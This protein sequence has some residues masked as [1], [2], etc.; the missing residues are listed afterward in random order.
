[1]EFVKAR[2][3]IVSS[4]SES[5]LHPISMYL[6]TAALLA[7]GGCQQNGDAVELKVTA[8]L[9]SSTCGAAVELEDTEE[10]EVTLTREDDVLT[11]YSQDTGTEM[12][13]SVDSDNQITLATTSTFQV[14][15]PSAVAS[16]CSVRR[17]DAYSGT[18]KESSSDAITGFE[19]E[20]LSTYTE[21]TNYSCDALI[22]AQGGFTDLPCEVNYEL[23]G[24]KK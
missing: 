2:I 12:E 1:M 4:L 18:L 23:V 9:V 8:T 6:A 3:V 21:A 20:V 17:H 22:G 16:G 10:F 15:E 7:L 11:W 24:T 13:G 14:T 19:V 5:P